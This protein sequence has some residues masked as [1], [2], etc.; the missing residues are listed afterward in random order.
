MWYISTGNGNGN[1][2]GFGAVTAVGFIPF[3]FLRLFAP[4]QYLIATLMTFV[5]L[6]LVVGY[7]WQDTGRLTVS[8]NSGIGI[9]VA[10]RRMLLV[11]I[12]IA[13]GVIVMLF[14]KPPS[15]RAAARMNFSKLTSKKILP[16]YNSII[17][18]WA[19][20][21]TDL[22]KSDEAIEKSLM[23]KPLPEQPSLAN[24]RGKMLSSYELIKDLQMQV[25]MAKLEVQAR[26]KWP[27]ARYEQLLK[28]QT[29][30]V[31]IKALVSIDE[32][33]RLLIT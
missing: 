10:Y 18:A 31:S 14:P 8:V 22:D 15:T 3:V 1:P 28:T 21:A 33:I 17:E 30:M 13:A 2:Y 26:G 11:I 27:G 16:L 9:V 4:R 23:H 29:R 32:G 20:Q 7:S 24:F 25:A 12:G 6:I 19:V 5:T